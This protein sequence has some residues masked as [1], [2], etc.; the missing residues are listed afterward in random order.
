[1]MI[2]PVATQ[3]RIDALNKLTFQAA[4]LI[5]DQGWVQD[6]MVGDAGE[7]CIISAGHQ[8]G[9]VLDRP[10]LSHVLR[11]ILD[12]LGHAEKWNDAS[13]R[14]KTDVI[15]YLSRVKITHNEL[16][17]AFGP[18]WEDVCFLA[19]MFGKMSYEEMC[20]WVLSVNESDDYRMLVHLDQ[21]E[22]PDP[23]EIRARG[24]VCSAASE[25]AAALDLPPR[26]PSVGLMTSKIIR[27][28]LRR[29]A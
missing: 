29:R 1:M 3:E 12:D 7:L 23:R 15:G 13:A 20:D 11:E 16:E 14:S 25:R 24:A 26:G 18:R 6:Q 9:H 5:E 4:Y 2:A 8:A 10:G 19:E 17:H 27:P 22:K 28:T 21:Q